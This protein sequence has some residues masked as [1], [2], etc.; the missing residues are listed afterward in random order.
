MS[1]G[2]GG[3]DGGGS[4][5]HGDLVVGCCV[6]SGRRGRGGGRCGDHENWFESR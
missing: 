5:G 4:G 2:E 1:Y 3:P 6:A